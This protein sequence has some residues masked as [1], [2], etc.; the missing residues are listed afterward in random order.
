MCL[1]EKIVVKIN[2][3]NKKKQQKINKYL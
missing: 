3:V 2:K 1:E